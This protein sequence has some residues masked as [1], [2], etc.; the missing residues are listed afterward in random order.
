MSFNNHQEKLKQIY[1]GGDF[2]YVMNMEDVEACG[3][4]LFLFLMREL[5][6]SED[7]RTTEEAVRR[8]RGAISDLEGLLKAIRALEHADRKSTGDTQDHPRDL[9]LLQARYDNAHARAYAAPTPEVVEAQRKFEDGVIEIEE[10]EA[11]LGSVT[12]H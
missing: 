10:F 1:G 6:D 8:I 7:C 11:V 5:S 12:P 3:D 9:R 2:A 4:T